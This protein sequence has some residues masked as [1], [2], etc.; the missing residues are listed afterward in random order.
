[1]NLPKPR[2]LKV[3]NVSQQKK[4]YLDK[5]N[6]DYLVQC[7]V[8][9][10]KSSAKFGRAT[11]IVAQLMMLLAKDARTI[12]IE[13]GGGQIFFVHF[14]HF[15][16]FAL[17]IVMF[18]YKIKLSSILLIKFVYQ[19]LTNKQDLNFLNCSSYGKVFI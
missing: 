11:H 18:V 2:M 1:M 14:A 15:Q 9:G 5:I 3:N 17:H 8:I 6:T 10:M 12:R 7:V 19:G 4:K 13:S 16:N